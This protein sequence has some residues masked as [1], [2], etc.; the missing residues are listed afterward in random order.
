MTSQKRSVLAAGGVLWRAADPAS[1]PLDTAA[2]DTSTRGAAGRVEVALIHRPRYDDWTLPKGKCEAGE[3]LVGTAVREINEE[4][5]HG[6]VLGRHLACV[7]YAMS[8]SARKRVHYWS[9][10][11]TGGTFEVNDEVDRMEWVPL[12]RVRDR[13]TYRADR[14]VVAEFARLP[15]DLTTVLVVRHARA[16]RK[17]RYR[18]DDRL[19]PLDKLGRLQAE[20]LSDQ[21]VAFG[22]QRLHSA[23]R[24]RCIQTLEPLAHR[25][26]VPITMEP[27]LSEESFRDDPTAALAR[28]TAI[29]EKSGTR[30]ICSQGKVIPDL[31]A[32]WT[33]GTDVTLPRSRNRKASM[34]VLSLCDGSVV[35]VDHLAS[36][37]PESS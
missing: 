32:A 17:S 30:V 4:T 20:K 29:A 26:H 8:S 7:D 15:A 18:G 10:R 27:T 14:R 13:L 31:L 24:T 34:W 33:A 23:D 37:V 2:P 19:R 6:V 5:G 21:C 12:G 28:I 35:A 1:R 25:L 9:A 22:A 3:T 36:P 16:G 11:S